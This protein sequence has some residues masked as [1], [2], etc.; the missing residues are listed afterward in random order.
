MLNILPVTSWWL[1]YHRQR[2][3]PNRDPHGVVIVKEDIATSHEEADDIIAQQ[4]IMCAKEHS[5]ATVVVADDTDV[6]ILLL[7]LFERM[8]YL[9]NIYD[10]TDSG[11]ITCRH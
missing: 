6:F 1:C 8:P 2:R 11:K 9:S 5:G 7:S 3:C 10:L 4:A